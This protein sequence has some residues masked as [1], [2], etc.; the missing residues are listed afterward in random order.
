[1][2]KSFSSH[3]WFSPRLDASSLFL[4]VDCHVHEGEMES[5]REKCSSPPLASGKLCCKSYFYE[6]TP[7][8]SQYQTLSDDDRYGRAEGRRRPTMPPQRRKN[9]AH[10][11]LT[12]AWTLS[13]RCRADRVFYDLVINGPSATGNPAGPNPATL[14]LHTRGRVDN[15]LLSFVLSFFNFFMSYVGF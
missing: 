10:E 5:D 4:T 8:S 15:L 3:S 7:D 6:A 12:D 1:M 14:V 2:Y 9:G 13:S 11:L